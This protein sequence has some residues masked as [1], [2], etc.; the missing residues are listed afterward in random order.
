MATGSLI[1]NITSKS[2]LKCQCIQ[3]CLAR[4]ATLSSRF[5]HSVPLLKSLHWLP[6]QSRII[7]KF[8]SIA[9]QTLSSEE[10]SYLHSVILLAC[11]PRGLRSSGVHLLSVPRV[12]LHAGTRVFSVAVPTL[13]MMM[14]MMMMIDVFRP[15]FAHGPRDLQR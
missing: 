6:V 10:P 3:N 2:I 15:L 12:K 14:M 5:S 4:V 8:C 1:H 13:W 7:F 9:Y 11:N